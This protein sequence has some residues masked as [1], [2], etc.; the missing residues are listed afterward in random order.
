MSSNQET[1]GRLVWVDWMKVW[2][3]L[4]VIWG[5][6]FSAGHVFLY[7]FSV[8]VFCVISGFLYKKSPDWKS[9]LKKC[10]RQLLVPTVIMSVLMQAEAWLR[11]LSQGESYGISWPWFFEWLLLGHRWCMGPCWYFYTLAVIR[12]VMQLLPEK[13][14]VYMVLFMVLSAGAVAFHQSGWNVSNA[15]VNVLVCMPLFLTGVLLQPLRS[16]LSGLRNYLT[17]VLVLTAAVAT[18]YLCGRYN[19]YVW[20]YLAGYGNNYLLY[21]AGG[22]GGTAMLYT[23]SL[24]LSRLPYRNMVQ[25]LSRGSILIV[26]LHIIIVRRLTELSDRLWAEDLALAVLILF[27]FVPVIRLAELFFPT[28]LG[29]HR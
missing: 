2:A 9:C 24:W 27:A 20:M 22:V 18:V 19:G 14:W 7:V 11:C 21:I 15:N 23:V 16:M 8:Q 12:I 17:E 5:H 6:F 28:I 1:S 13:R 4:A 3:T 26:G 29:R 25:T 10:F